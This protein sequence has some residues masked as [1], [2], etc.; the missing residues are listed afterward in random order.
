MAV[1]PGVAALAKPEIERER[2]DI[3][4]R[5]AFARDQRIGQ[6]LARGEQVQI[7]P[8]GKGRAAVCLVGRAAFTGHRHDAVVLARNIVRIVEA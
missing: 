1:A 3:L 7:A 5:A 8:A 4:D 6:V 2:A